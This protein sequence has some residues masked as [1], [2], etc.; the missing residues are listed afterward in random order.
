MSKSPPVH[1]PAKT[2]AAITAL[3]A[4]RDA[5][6]R[7]LADA[8]P[9][10]R[11]LGVEVTRTGDE[12]TTALPFAPR[13]IGNPI[14]PAIHGGVT[15]SFLEITALLQLAWDQTWARIEAG[16]EARERI[17]A[18]AFPPWPRTV[19]VSIDYLRSG[20]PTAMFARAR[21]ARKGRRVANVRVEAWQD[22]RDR[23]FAAAHGHFL[24]PE[25]S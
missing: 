7:R 8:S 5:A 12:L 3:E 19:D 20:R 4:E 11:F 10:A 2:L 13:L 18:G 22:A 14:L 21:V 9:Y 25:E 15:G 23:P 16:G 1:D 17:T 6:L 24:L